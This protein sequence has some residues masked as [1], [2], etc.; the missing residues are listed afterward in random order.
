M[1]NL[2]AGSIP[3]P[4]SYSTPGFDGQCRGP[5][6]AQVRLIRSPPGELTLTDFVYVAAS[7]VIYSRPSHN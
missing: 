1:V 4:A 6:I 3:A 2:F 7:P 5:S